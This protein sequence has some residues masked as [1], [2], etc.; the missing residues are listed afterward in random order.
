M[1]PAAAA[2]LTPI[3]NLTGMGGGAASV[4]DIHTRATITTSEVTTAV[5]TAD[6]TTQADLSVAETTTATLTVD[7]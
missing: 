5:I 6:E 4:I 1:T 2:S 7:P 3:L